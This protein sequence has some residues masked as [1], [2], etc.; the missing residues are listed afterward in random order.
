MNITKHIGFHALNSCLQ[1]CCVFKN[2]IVVRYTDMSNLLF[3]TVL[4]AFCLC[5]PGIKIGR[6]SVGGKKPPCTFIIYNMI[7]EI[8]IPVLSK[9][10]LTVPVI[11]L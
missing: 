10:F 3:L 7:H 6:I 5:I 2:G 4:S 8:E 9:W 11:L 1:T